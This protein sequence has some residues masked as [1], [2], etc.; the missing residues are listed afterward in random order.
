MASIHLN[1]HG[2]K[3]THR[4]FN[5]VALCWSCVPPSKPQAQGNQLD[6]WLVVVNIILN[7][8]MLIL[9]LLNFPNTLIIMPSFFFYLFW[10]W[11]NYVF[12][13]YFRWQCLH[14]KRET[15]CHSNSWTRGTLLSLQ[16]KAGV[17]VWNRRKLCAVSCLHFNAIYGM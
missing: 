15:F 2:W 12:C 14:I 5:N 4:V 8:V 1:K 16:D 3:K 6:H 11:E 13:H 17:W 9:F 10:L 7:A